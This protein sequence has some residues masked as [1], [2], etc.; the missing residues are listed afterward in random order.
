MLSQDQ[1]VDVVRGRWRAMRSRRSQEAECVGSFG[2]LGRVPILSEVGSHWG[3]LE[4][5]GRHD[6]T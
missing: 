2:A 1:G 3:H 4:A 6:P 5:K